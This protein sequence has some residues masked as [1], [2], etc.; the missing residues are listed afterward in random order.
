METVRFCIF[1]LTRE[2]QVE[3]NRKSCKKAEFKVFT[4]TVQLQ[5]AEFRFTCERLLFKVRGWKTKITNIHHAGEVSHRSKKRGHI[6]DNLQTSLAA[7]RTGEYWPEIVAVRTA[8]SEVR[9][10]R[11]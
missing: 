9:T 6:M 10:K 3:R 8:R 7:D 11:T 5:Q 2:V 1:S 4:T